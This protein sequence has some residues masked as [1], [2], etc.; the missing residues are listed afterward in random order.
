MTQLASIV[1]LLFIPV[2]LFWGISQRIN[3]RKQPH[4]IKTYA[5]IALVIS[6][7]VTLGAATGAFISGSLSLGIILFVAFGYS[8]RKAIARIQQLDGNTTFRYVPLYL[9]FIPVI[10]FLVRFS[11]LKPA[12]DFSRNYIISQSK[13]L[14]DDIEGFRIRTGHYPTSLISV[15]EDYKPGIRSVKRYYYEPYGQAY[16]L[17]FE[18]FSSELTVKEIVMYNPLD[19]QEMTSHNQDLLILSSADLT[20]QRGYF[21]TYKLQ[22]PHW[23]SFWFD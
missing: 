13:K 12:T 3:R 19:A 2:G 6:C 4:E 9:V 11:L 15:W 23:K 18:Q 17:Y 14:I 16:N 10:L 22:Q 21:R 20:M 7:F 5:F 1:G 8:A